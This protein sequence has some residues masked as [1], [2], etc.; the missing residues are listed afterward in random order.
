V[1]RGRTK[2]IVVAT[3]TATHVGQLALDVGSAT[4]GKPPLLERVER[5]TNVITVATL[6]IAALIGVFGASLGR[7]TASEMFLFVVALAVS[8]IPE[9]LP[10]AMTVALAIATTRMA[11]RGVIV[12]RLTAV[13]GLG[14]CTMIATD[15]TGTL[16]VNELTVREVRLPNGKKFIVTGEGFVP[17]DQVLTD[18]KPAEPGSDPALGS[19][20]RAGVL[21][22]EADLHQRN[23]N[24]EW[25]GDTV[26]VA[27]LSFGQMLGWRR[28]TTL[29]VHPQVKEIPFESE[30]QYAATFNDQNTFAGV[31]VVP[32]S[33]AL[34]LLAVRGRQRAACW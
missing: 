22:N 7:Y 19:L 15:K 13:E 4:G 26:D 34:R 6:M 24:W 29:D 12:R 10:V 27:L 31:Q 20:A 33:W 17:S 16:T 21:C 8:A 23:G 11:R 14:S 9:G 5:F 32:C 28:A 3:G 1:T 18:D 25:R 2:G 30:Y